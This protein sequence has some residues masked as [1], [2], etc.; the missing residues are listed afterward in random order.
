VLFKRERR[1]KDLYNILEIERTASQEDIKKAFRKQ[2]I[3]Y[4][5]DKNPDNPA[6][7]EEKF[8]E[9]NAAYEILSDEQKKAKYDRGGNIEQDFAAGYRRPHPGWDHTNPDNW[10]G[11]NYDD[12]KN[13]LNGTGFT[14][15]FD[16]YFGQGQAASR[17]K[18]IIAEMIITL[19]DAYQ[20]LSRDI[21]ALPGEQ[22]FKVTIHPGVMSGQKFRIDGK[23]H[24]QPY[25][26][27]LP[28]GDVVLTVKVV[29]HDIFERN[30]PD[31]TS[32]VNIQLYDAM[33]G[34]EVIINSIDGKV[35]VKIPALSQQ[36]TK[37][38][39]KGKGMPVYNGK[40]FGDMYIKLNIVLPSILDNEQIE[41]IKKIKEIEEQK[42]QD[43]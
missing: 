31:L 19:E 9:V 41:L 5:P 16:K 8:K 7:A 32:T 43:K 10:G 15:M 37:L 17:G 30:G 39:L 33:L 14:E 20:G 26:S 4:H 18:D 24:K 36:G 29:D 13:D 6:E 27:E 2:A 40:T 12:I 3:K 1:L 38:K 25:N 28:A 34:G 11:F 22:P 23:G 21:I 42:L 35:K